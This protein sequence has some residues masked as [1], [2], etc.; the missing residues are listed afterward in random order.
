M[1]TIDAWLAALYTADRGKQLDK[2]MLEFVADIK[3]FPVLEAQAKQK[4]KEL[5]DL[6]AAR[7]EQAC[8]YSSEYRSYLK[9]ALV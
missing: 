8:A 7:G 4:L 1:R 2:K 5:D 9:K 3:E 6:V